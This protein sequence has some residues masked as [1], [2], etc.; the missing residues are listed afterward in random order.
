MGAASCGCSTATPLPSHDGC[1]C[2]RVPYLTE[3]I[4]ESLTAVPRGRGES[5]DREAAKWQTEYLSS[6]KLR[7]GPEGSAPHQHSWKAAAAQVLRYV[8]PT[9]SPLRPLKEMEKKNGRCFDRPHWKPRGEGHAGRLPTGGGPAVSTHLAASPC[10][11]AGAAPL[12]YRSAMQ[13][14]LRAAGSARGGAAARGRA[15]RHRRG[16][17]AERRRG[18]GG[19]GGGGAGRV[20]GARGAQAAAS[21]RQPRERRGGLRSGVSLPLGAPVPVR[22]AQV[23]EREVVVRRAGRRRKGRKERAAAVGG[24]GFGGSGARRGAPLTGQSAGGSRAASRPLGAV[25]REE[26]SCRPPRAG[27]ACEP[28]T[29]GGSASLTSRR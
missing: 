10:R 15:L 11:A 12:R 5:S 1:L 8:F 29:G 17:P 3:G 20:P 21:R 22:G 4:R 27:A 2:P 23:R 28:R 9:I 18:R 25:R 19:A 26:G 6:P 24:L 16:G 7:K 14:P 13:G